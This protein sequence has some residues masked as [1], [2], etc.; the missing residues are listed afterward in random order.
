MASPRTRKVLKEVRVQD[1]N[2]TCF[3]CGA[4]NPQWVSVTYGIWICLECSGKHRGLGV[5]LSFVRSVTMDKWK[6]VELEKMKAGGNGK[7]RQFLEMQDDYDPC[8]SM[9][10]K[11]NSRAAALY[12]DKVAT[13]AEGQEWSVETSSARNWTPPQP[14]MMGGSS[15]RSSAGSAQT[16]SSSGDKPFEDWLNDDM[17][18]YQS[19]GGSGHQENRYVGFGNTVDP[20]KKED[21]FLNNA[22]TSLYSGWSNFTVGASKF[23]SAAKESASKLG[24]QATQKVQGVSS[25]GWKD[26]TSFFSGKSEDMGQ[27]S[28]PEGGY[29]QGTGDRYQ[30]ASYGK[31]FWETFGSSEEIKKP[32][33]SP[34]GDS[35][36][37]PEN[38]TG[39]KSSDSWEVWGSGTTS[40]N[41]NSNSDSWENWDSHWDSTEGKGKKGEK[42]PAA[43]DGWDNSW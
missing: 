6:D 27:S 28:E 35:W 12:R 34:S 25:K 17:T 5:H 30:N 8:W 15:I 43:E 33:K 42:A 10:E 20:P 7:F 18:S 21:D 13:L 24:T 23:A 26:V 11:Y 2:N 39:R 41:K 22:M 1:E 9:Q 40:N 32:S 3:E 37:F 36:T 4:F 14:K 38:S 31:S 19:G 16:G 29:Q